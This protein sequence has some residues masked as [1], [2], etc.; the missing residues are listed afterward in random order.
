MKMTKKDL[1][2]MYHNNDNKTVAKSLNISVPTLLKLVNKAGIRPKGKG[3]ST[4]IE[5]V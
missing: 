3:N 2:E 5:I 4:R 1:E